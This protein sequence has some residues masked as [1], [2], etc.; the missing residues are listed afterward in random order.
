MV[1]LHFLLSNIPPNLSL[2]ISHVVILSHL[3]SP[4]LSN[5]VTMPQLIAEETVKCAL[6]QSGHVPRQHYIKCKKYKMDIEGEAGD[7]VIHTDTLQ[8]IK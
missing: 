1:S 3:F 2:Y 4:Y 8:I 5:I 7:S 6:I